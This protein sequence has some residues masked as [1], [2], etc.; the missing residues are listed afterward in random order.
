MDVFPLDIWIYL[1]EGLSAREV[2]R[3]RQTC[4]GLATWLP[5]GLAHRRRLL[6]ED[7]HGAHIVGTI[8][9]VELGDVIGVCDIPSRGMYK[10]IK[11]IYWG[12]CH[13]SDLH[14]MKMEMDWSPDTI[15]QMAKIIGAFRYRIYSID[16]DAIHWPCVYTLESGEVI[17]DD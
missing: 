17:I 11:H 6:P 14:L 10:Y 2:C 1:S 12:F 15:V 7:L 13:L 3:L 8:L 4:R 16:A 9:Q 5:L